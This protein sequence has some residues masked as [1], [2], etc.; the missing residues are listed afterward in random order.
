M[1]DSEDEQ[2][3][4]HRAIDIHTHLSTPGPV[5]SDDELRVAI[6]LSHRWG[7]KHIVLLGNVTAMGGPYPTMADISA[8]N[9]HTLGVMQRHPDVYIGFCYLNPAHPPAFIRNEV[10]RCVMQGGMRGLKLWIAVKAT[11]PRLDTV[12]ELAATLGIPV[13]HHA[14]Y[15]QTVFAYNESTPAEVAQLA[16]RFPQVSIIMAHLSGCGCR[17][18]LDIVDVPNVSID[19]SGGQPESGLVEYAMRHLGSHRVLYGSD[20]PL[21]DFGT[22]LGRILGANLDERQRSDVLWSNAAR[23]LRMEERP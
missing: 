10:E 14:W 16:R 19:T 3:P 23:L 13:L 7:I 8:I 1:V 2:K 4:P 17:G 6:R 9:T 15:K 5:P 21:R 22:Q 12:M 11:D 20:W 18:V